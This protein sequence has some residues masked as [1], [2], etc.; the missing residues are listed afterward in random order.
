M[1]GLVELLRGFELIDPL[2][3]GVLCG[4]VSWCVGF[5]PGERE[6]FL[7]V[8]EESTGF[9]FGAGGRN[10]GG[11]KNDRRF[12]PFKPVESSLAS[13]V[14]PEPSQLLLELWCG[15][16]VANSSSTSQLEFIELVCDFLDQGLENL[17]VMSKP[18]GVGCVFV[19][20]QFDQ[21]AEGNIN[22][23]AL[24][25]PCWE[26]SFIDF[27]VRA[28]VENQEGGT[29]KRGDAFKRSVLSVPL[30]TPALVCIGKKTKKVASSLVDIVFECLEH[31][32]KK[33]WRET[34][35]M[36]EAF[37]VEFDLDLCIFAFLGL[38]NE[39]PCF[40]SRVFVE[41]WQE[42]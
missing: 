42:L 22:V 20:N 15:F 21:G 3:S 27:L 32:S 24:D 40:S 14:V 11:S 9:S 8:S 35:R 6:W 13:V 37:F 16:E 39:G 34:L 18:S 1:K 5:V 26:K 2:E 19:L 38:L 17:V 4:V 12:A 10:S 7:I 25:F 41:E 28:S 36:F 29:K 31:L 23:V 30:P 33:D